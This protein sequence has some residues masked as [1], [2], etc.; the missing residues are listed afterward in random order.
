MDLRTFYESHPEFFAQRE[1]YLLRN[2]TRSNGVGFFEAGNFYPD[3]ILWLL[4]KKGQ[5]ITF[6]DPK[7]IV[8]LERLEDPKIAFH[9]T[10]KDI[11]K[12][13]GDPSVTLN[14]FII[15]NTRDAEV[16]TWGSV[17]TSYEIITSFSS[18]TTS[19]PTS[20]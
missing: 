18:K 16:A 4:D 12:E 19:R 14:S 5:F 20:T 9:Q 17:K 15:S 13:L 2:L 6:I 10:I 8:R 3:F 7:G 11:E 1:L